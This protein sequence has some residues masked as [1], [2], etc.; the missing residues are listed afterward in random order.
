VKA[1]ARET[2]RCPEGNSIVATGANSRR[3]ALELMLLAESP[4][5]MALS[6][7]GSELSDHHVEAAIASIHAHASRPFEQ[8]LRVDQR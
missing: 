7:T 2:L 3:E 5:L 6:A 4:K 1:L 8:V